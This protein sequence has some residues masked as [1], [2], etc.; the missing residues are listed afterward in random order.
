[1]SA[2]SDALDRLMAA[3]KRATILAVSAAL[4]IAAIICFVFFGGLTAT[5]KISF[6][7]APVL[8]TS[9]AESKTGSYSA[10]WADVNG[11][12]RQMIAPAEY[13]ILGVGDLVCVRRA[14][15]IIGITK[16]SIATDIFCPQLHRQ[17]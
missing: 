17:K 12:E 10:V 3:E 15:F 8:S 11:I 16:Y 13:A 14:D 6:Q 1:M 7:I 5:A 2:I 4:A 9:L